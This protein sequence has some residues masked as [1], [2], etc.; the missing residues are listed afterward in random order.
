MNQYKKFWYDSMV[1]LVLEVFGASGAVWGTSEVLT[2]RDSD[3]QDIWRGIASTVGFLFL[4]R[5][6]IQQY[7][8]YPLESS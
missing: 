3:T 6:G 2:L 8:S 7:R 5:F 1:K 4:I